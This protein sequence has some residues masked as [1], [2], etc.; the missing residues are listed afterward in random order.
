[1]DER[2]IKNGQITV[3]QN[4]TGAKRRIEI[5]GELKL[6]IDRILRR[7]AGL[8][9]R[10]TRLVVMENGQ[11][12]TVSMLRKRFDDARGAAGVPKAAFQMRDLRAKAATDKEESTGS[13][14]ETRDQLGHTTVGMT[15][16]YIR[17]RRGAKVTPTK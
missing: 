10:S 5:L 2:H 12:M 9:V 7:K 4:K 15:E 6:V 1:M 16:Q 8:N 17:K 11:P 3:T 13:I 14:R